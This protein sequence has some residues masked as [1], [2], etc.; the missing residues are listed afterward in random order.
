MRDRSG[1]GVA[2]ILVE[3]IVDIGQSYDVALSA[4]TGADGT[5]ELVGMPGSYSLVFNAARAAGLAKQYWRAASHA[6][7]AVRLPVTADQSAIDATLD[8]IFALTGRVDGVFQQV[9]DAC[10]HAMAL[11]DAPP[12]DLEAYRGLK[13]ASARVGADGRFTLRGVPP[14]TYRVAFSEG[15]SH[16]GFDLTREV[17]WW[18][19]APFGPRD[20]PFGFATSRPVTVSKDLGGID[21]ILPLESA[22]TG[23]ELRCDLY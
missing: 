1:A 2:G 18:Q 22:S 8:R 21:S 13:V 23:M 10:A 12:S 5:Y 19:G 4:T 3:A 11:T 16:G 20:S 17:Y 14:G 15:V 9:V 7:G 6:G